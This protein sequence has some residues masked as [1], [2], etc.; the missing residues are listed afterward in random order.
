MDVR[1]DSR[2]S[3]VEGAVGKPRG[4]APDHPKSRSEAQEPKSGSTR[5]QVRCRVAGGGMKRP[6]S[7]PRAEAI[8]SELAD[9]YQVL[10]PV[11]N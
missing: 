3:L 8:D 5:L 6:A 11:R 2:R 10:G 7:D 9:E 1:S 4:E